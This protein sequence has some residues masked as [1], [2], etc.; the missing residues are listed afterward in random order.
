VKGKDPKKVEAAWRFAKYLD[1]PQVQAKWAVTGYIPIRK[2]SVQLPAVQQLWQ[3]KPFYKVA[4]DQLASTNNTVAAKGPVMG[5]F[6]AVETAI[7]D[8]MESMLA[9]GTNPDTALANAA[10]QSNSLISD[11]NQRAGG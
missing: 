2:S 7:V 10:K 4:Y 5:P 11:Y 3:Q 9:K 8:S 1:E 6:N